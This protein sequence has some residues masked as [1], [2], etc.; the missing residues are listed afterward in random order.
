MFTPRNLLPALMAV[1]KRS[2]SYTKSA[3]K[4]KADAKFTGMASSGEFSRIQYR[5]KRGSKKFIRRKKAFSKK[6]HKV[7]EESNG[8]GRYLFQ[9][10][11]QID[12]PVGAQDQGYIKIY[13]PEDLIYV[14]QQMFPQ[15]TASANEIF[16]IDNL[17]F[18][19]LITNHSNNTGILDVYHMVCRQDSD[20]SET[21]QNLWNQGLNNAQAV[22]TTARTQA[23]LTPFDVNTIGTK[24]KI[25]SKRRM[26]FNPGETK[27]I[28]KRYSRTKLIKGSGQLYDSAN[29]IKEG[30]KGV[31]EW[32]MFNAYGAPIQDDT[33]STSIN[34]GSAHFNFIYGLNYKVRRTSN[35][36]DNTKGPFVL[37]RLD[38][39]SAITTETLFPEANPV[40]V[41][42][43]DA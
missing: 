6:V 33:T 41:T 26:M 12:V 38:N 18:D 42:F 37:G 14:Y 5:S 7:L 32:Y 3:T 16:A 13:S 39:R 43:D 8:Y 1:A 22:V 23:F 36:S 19:C 30:L 35:L 34:L 15:G 28:E 27:Q 10:K 2:I 24:Y 9:N 4:K 11:L 20:L 25:L 21:P 40:K 17:V 31:T 29:V